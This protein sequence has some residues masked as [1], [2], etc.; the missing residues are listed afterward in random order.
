MILSEPDLIR[1]GECIGREARGPLFLGLQGPLG[2]GKS[3]LARAVA[4]GAGVEGPIPS[5]TFNLLFRYGTPEG[6]TL[7]HIDL[8]RLESADELWE[9][10]WEDLGRAGEVVLVEWPERAGD[11]LPDDRWEIELVVPGR[12]SGLREVSVSRFGHPPRIPGFPVHLQN[13]RA[14]GD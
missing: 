14:E 11:L 6:V 9:L 8:Y 2:A 1:W 3:V 13:S 4:R 5:P 7:V 10:G 12:G